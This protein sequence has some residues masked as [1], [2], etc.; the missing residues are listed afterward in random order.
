MTNAMTFA[1]TIVE[2]YLAGMDEAASLVASNITDGM[3]K[4]V[5]YWVETMTDVR[6]G[7]WEDHIEPPRVPW[8]KNGKCTNNGR[9]I[10]NLGYA[11]DGCPYYDIKS[12]K[13]KKTSLSNLCQ[14]CGLPKSMCACKEIA[15]EQSRLAGKRVVWL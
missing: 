12:E 10:C 13:K 1:G 7:F 6:P 5:I 3:Q 4:E 2:L 8:L 14:T 11:C 9:Y 15:K